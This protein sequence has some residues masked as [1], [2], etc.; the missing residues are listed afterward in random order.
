MPPLDDNQDL[1][2]STDPTLDDAADPANAG[3]PD[4]ANS[5]DA[6][7]ENSDESLLSVV[8]DVV[9]EGR[10]DKAEAASPAE[11]EEGSDGTGEPKKDDEDYSDVPFNKHPRFQQL[12]RKAKA[13]EQDAQRYQN[14]QGFL[15]QTGLSAEEAADGLSIMGLAKTDPAGAWEKIK[16]WVQ[17]LLVASGEVLADD[18]Q[19]RVAAG[20]MTQAAALELSRARAA[21]QNAAAARSFHEQRAQR[22]QQ[23]DVS[24]ALQTAAQT[25]EDNRRAKDPNFDAKH[26]AVMAEVRQLIAEEGM[27]TSPQG[28]RA[29]LDKAYKAVNERFA[30]PAPAPQK[31][32]PIRPVTGGQVAGGQPLPKDASALDIVRAHRRTA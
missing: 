9:A 24:T 15:D 12:V 30:P 6:T 16:P 18:L 17:K 29:Q 21:S 22:Q 14:V 23:T 11:G 28:V 27:P 4:D 25:W 10:K 3:K 7:G 8:R 2:P 26:R 5:S 32:P 20:E 19:Q 1:E 31:R 13:F